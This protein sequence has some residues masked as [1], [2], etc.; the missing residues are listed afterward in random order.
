MSLPAESIPA[1]LHIRLNGETHEVPVAANQ[2]LLAAARDGGVEPPFTCQK[3]ACGACMAKLVVGTV[4][5]LGGSALEP[6]QKANDYILTCQ[7]IP[8][9]ELIAVDYG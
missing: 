5:Q 6:E 8:T 1:T 9:S 4:H 7:S 3:G 2:T